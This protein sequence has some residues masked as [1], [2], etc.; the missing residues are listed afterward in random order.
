VIDDDDDDDDDDDEGDRKNTYIHMIPNVCM[1]HMCMYHM[2]E[3]CMY[4]HNMVAHGNNY[5]VTP[6]NECP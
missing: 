4:I 1:Y 5:I 2:M 6:M 3:L